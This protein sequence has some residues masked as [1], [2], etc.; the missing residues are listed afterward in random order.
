MSFKSDPVMTTRRLYKHVLH[1]TVKSATQLYADK[2]I[3][4]SIKLIQTIIPLC[5]LALELTDTVKMHFMIAEIQFIHGRF[6]KACKF[7]EI[8]IY[9]AKGS[10]SL[11]HICFDAMIMASECQYKLNNFTEAQ[12]MLKICLD[13]AFMIDDGEKERIV[14]HKLALMFFY[15]GNLKD[16]SYFYT[17]ANECLLEKPD[18]HVKR[19]YQMCRLNQ[20]SAKKN[21]VNNYALLVDNFWEG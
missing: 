17:R 11:I 19:V 21:Y 7:C 2:K 16:A 18:S 20:K 12:K 3:S 5:Q 8:V 10:N 15:D 1:Q 6:D 9:L 4:D 14:Y 13:K